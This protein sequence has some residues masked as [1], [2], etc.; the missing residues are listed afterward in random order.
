LTESC[1]DVFLGLTGDLNE[2]RVNFELRSKLSPQLTNE[3]DVS[4][5][6]FAQNW[7][8]TNNEQTNRFNFERSSKLKLNELSV[9]WLKVSYT[10]YAFGPNSILSFAQNWSGDSNLSFA[11]IW[12]TPRTRALGARVRRAP[13]WRINFELRSKLRLNETTNKRTTKPTRQFWAPLKIDAQR[14]DISILSFAQNWN[15]NEQRTNEHNE[16]NEPTFQFWASL[17]IETS[18]NERF[19]FELRSKLKLN[20][21]FNFVETVFQLRIFR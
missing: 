3:H 19:N 12:I 10:L 17:K 5:L 4:I 14:T 1:Q 13:S 16:H 7:N 9:F 2:R 20:K 18:T 6:S 21:Q 15:S 11:Q 8:S